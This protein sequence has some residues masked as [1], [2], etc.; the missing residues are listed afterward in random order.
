MTDVALI[1]PDGFTTD[2]ACDVEV[3]LG[4]LVP[5]DGLDTAIL[6]SLFCDR[7]ANA[8]DDLP[9][10]SGDRRG[11]WADAYPDVVGDLWGSRLWLLK[12]SKQ[13]S[14]TLTKAQEYAQEALAWMVT[15]QVASSVTVI[16]SYPLRGWI[17][18]F[19]TL[20]EPADGAQSHFSYLWKF[21]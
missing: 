7:L 5:D 16:T 15:D 6:L 19:I 21:S 18:F 1:P 17:K 13:T 12:R 10:L 8:D 3:A 9:D 2:F 4:D 14:D 20:T 11:W